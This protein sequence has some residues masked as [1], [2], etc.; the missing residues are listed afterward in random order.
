M[1]YSFIKKLFIF[2]GKV[3]LYFGECD[4]YVF[5]VEEILQNIK[6]KVENHYRK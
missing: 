3:L 1:N 4:K 5:S 2:M 6:Y